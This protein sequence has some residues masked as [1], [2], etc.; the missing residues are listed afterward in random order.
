MRR[1]MGHRM[2][3]LTH[4][5]LPFIISTIFLITTPGLHGQDA[6]VAG[7]LGGY[8]PDIDHINIWFEYKFKSFRSFLR[9]LSKAQRFRMSF[10]LFHNVGF[11]LFVAILIPMFI[12]L[13]PLWA[14]FLT[15][16]LGH[17]SL[18]FLDDKITIGRVTHW[19]YRHKT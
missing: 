15:A 14:I 2:H 17:L 18:D 13:Y 9:Y 12:R 4:L 19:R 10:L 7:L 1:D 11:M 8:I 6:I 16:F 3:N 5:T